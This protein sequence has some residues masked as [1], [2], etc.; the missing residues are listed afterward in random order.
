M[1]NKKEAYD[2]IDKVLTYCNYYT[3]VTVNSQEEG[4]TRFANSEI[5]QN[6]FKADNSV[7]IIVHDGKK[8]SK[9]A[10]NI[11]DDDS[12]REMVVAA[13]DNL[14]Y[15]PEG[16]FVTPEVTTPVEIAC[17]EYD[18]ELESKF[19][20]ASRAALIKE[21][22][23][24]LDDSF[25]GS[26]ALSL[27]KM[28]IAI[29]NNKGIKRYGRLDAVNFNA[30]VTHESGSSGYAEYSTNKVDDIDVMQLFRIAHLK[31][32]AALNPISIEPGSYTVILEPLAVGDLLNYM[33]YSG[34]S[35]R[36][37]QVGMSYLTGKKGQKA[38]REK[39]LI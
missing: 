12:L 30:V 16:E 3:M 18:E 22:I 13:E 34:F 14:K 17:E 25:T 6:V 5:H 11:L 26:G 38:M 39:S 33:N 28:V 2:L 1:L 35:S 23:E 29:G 24:A 37:V 19:G 20:I 7:E 4:L 32:K 10:T 31:A 36:S 21:G 27:T 8:Q 15:L 9:I